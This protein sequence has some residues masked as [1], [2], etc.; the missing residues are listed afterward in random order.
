MER[1]ASE[2]RFFRDATD[3]R[4]GEILDAAVAVFSEKGYDAGSMREI[5]ELVGVSEP[6][7]YRHFSSKEDICLALITV[8]SARIKSEVGPLLAAAE[9]AHIAETFETIFVNRTVA[10]GSY[11]PVVRTVMIASMH[12]PVFRTAFRESVADPILARLERLVPVVDAYYGIEADAEDVS[13]RV[14]TL[15]SMFVGQFITAFVLGDE[16]TSPTDTFM[17]VMGWTEP[18]A[19][20]A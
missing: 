7:L 11:L 6:A 13:T 15:L 14:R 17:R 2:P 16:L 8:V 12:S 9:P 4:K 1:P 18:T 10:V 3:D 20:S 19:A 5:A